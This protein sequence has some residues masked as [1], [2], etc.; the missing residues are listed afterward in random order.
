MIKETCECPPKTPEE[1]KRGT[2][3]RRGW[4][5]I[6]IGANCISLRMRHCEPTRIKC[7]VLEVQMYVTMAICGA[8]THAV[9]ELTYQVRRDDSCC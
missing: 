1:G 3:H 4:G 7:S 2:R 9:R 8:D 5:K 6:R